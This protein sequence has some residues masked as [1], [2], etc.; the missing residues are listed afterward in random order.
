MTPKAFKSRQK[1]NLKRR[2]RKL[3]VDLD[4]RDAKSEPSFYVDLK[5]SV[6][7]RS[8]EFN[9]KDPVRLGTHTKPTIDP[10]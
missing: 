8:F 10:L 9:T 2:D 6:P 5:N 1:G 4:D 3:E 7:D